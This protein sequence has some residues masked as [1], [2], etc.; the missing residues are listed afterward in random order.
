[1]K[2]LILAIYT[3]DEFYDKMMLQTNEYLHV[4][5]SIPKYYDDFVYYF[6]IYKPLVGVHMNK[7]YMIDRER[8]MLI[9][10]GTDSLMPGILYKT[11]DAIDILMNKLNMKFDF[12][13]RTTT[14]T[15]I[16]I[17]KII[18]ILNYTDQT[19]NNYMGNMVTLNW[20]DIPYG[21]IDTQQWGTKYCGGNFAIFNS[22]IGLDMV[23]NRDFFS[24]IYT[25]V[26]DVLIGYYIRMKVLDIQYLNL[27]IITSNSDNF[28]QN[29]LVS[30]N[31]SNK[32]NRI[33]DVNNHKKI[34]DCLI[35]EI[36][37]YIE[38]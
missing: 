3:E 16:N 34:N 7:D 5:T 30:F 1:M 26:D 36:T 27:N 9:I 11:L 38:C 21:I 20:I 29:R 17:P 10:N 37:K 8:N 14:A 13:M 18:E 4:L 33:I 12:I 2:L 35:Y 15:C 28:F 19:K 24:T 6:I 23:A 31:N 22:K 32:H 25:V